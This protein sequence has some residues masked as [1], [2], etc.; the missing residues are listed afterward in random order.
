ME[1]RILGPIEVV[2]GARRL[3]IAGVRQQ[4]ALATLVLA[5][6]R[7]VTVER[8]LEAIYGQDLP[9]TGRSQVQIG[10]SSLRRLFAAH[11][12]PD[13]IDTRSG[14]YSLRADEA[15]CDAV[16]FERLAADARGTADDE[17]AV[18]KYREAL[19]LW[20]GPALSGIDRHPLRDAAGRLEEL[21]ISAVEERLARELDLGRH[22]EV[23]GELAELVA[24]HPLRERLQGHL[25]RALHNCGRTAEA[26]QVYSRARHMLIEELG[27]EPGADLQQVH[28]AVL[29]ADPTLAPTL[30]PVRPEPAARPS[31][32]RPPR[33]LPSDIADFTG[34]REQLAEIRRHLDHTH[35]RSGDT[36]R[37]R[38]DTAVPVVVLA[39]P[40]GAGKSALAVHASHALCDQFP[41]GQ[42]YVDLHGG[43]A[44]PVGPAEALERFIRALDATGAPIPPGL[45]ERAEAYRDLLADREVLIVIDDAVDESQVAPLVPGNPASAV[46]VTSPNRLTGLPGAVHVEVGALAAEQSVRLLHRIVGGGRLAAQ[47]PAA[48]RVAE[49]CGHLPLALRIAGAR[50]SARPDW[51]A[52]RLADRLADQD[53]RLDELR[54]GDLDVRKRISRDYRSAQAPARSLLRRLTVLERPV[55]PGWVAAPLLGPGGRD[56]DDVLDELV[57]SRLIE[58]V[59]ARP[60][61]GCEYRLPELTRVFARERLAEEEPGSGSRPALRRVLGALLHL[62]DRAGV[63]LAECGRV[64]VPRAQ[65]D[66]ALPEELAGQLVADPLAW[67]DAEHGTL[68][69]AVRQAA[70]AGLGRL[71]RS[72]ADACVPLVQA[73][74]GSEEWRAAT[75]AVLESARRA[76]NLLSLTAEPF[77]AGP[78]YIVQ[79][80]H[81]RGELVEAAAAVADSI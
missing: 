72:L 68:L 9:P 67:F 26:L 60:G 80:Y 13:L 50:L 42:L 32:W 20:R 79:R 63:Q 64:P 69:A 41:G 75:G 35:D 58:V 76:Q 38:C 57:H 11:G 43:S 49:Y 15:Q 51:S 22:G 71:G 14:G 29:Q 25:M 37:G 65:F 46:V 48:A 61:G 73:G 44:R 56:A 36:G 55:F 5:A 81:G 21:R 2:C 40:A 16:R 54:H 34:R 52:G 7:V 70:D 45:D 77:E 27:L 10:I 66:W 74:G 18:A 1:F 33:L 19:R 3:E 23:V 24:E 17:Q 8:L 6:N 12:H 47:G 53:R 30:A 62:A 31:A 59:G 4:A 39:G 78:A 28:R